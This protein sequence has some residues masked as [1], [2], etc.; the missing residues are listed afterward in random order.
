MPSA[1]PAPPAVVRLV[2]G[3][4][5]F[6]LF[7]TNTVVLCSFLYLVTLLKLAVPLAAWKRGVSRFLVAIGEAWI[8]V[9]TFCL[10]VTQPTVYDVRGLEGLR[11]DVSYLVVSNHLSEGDIPVLQGI[12]L[13]RLPFLR[14]FL[15]QQLIRVPVLGLAWWAL[16]FPFMKRHSR[17]ELEKNPALRLEDLEATRRACEKF[18]HAP[19]AILNFVEGTRFTPAKHAR[20]GAEYRHLLLPKAG[21]LAFAASAMGAQL[22]GLVD[23]T[24]VYPYGA[25]TFWDVISRGLPEVVVR[26]RERAIPE[27]WFTGDYTEDAAFREGVQ[28]WVRALFREKDAEIASILA[29]RA[30]AAGPPV[31]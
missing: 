11:R 10:R 16:D 23:V 1:R 24:I 4:F 8:A 7:A 9:N 25:P 29:S 18:R 15:K 12:F 22:K 6:L 30:P 5:T 14:F 28:A 31:R 20:G 19:A 17:E 2:V 26:V 3:S 27:E 13:R 21:G